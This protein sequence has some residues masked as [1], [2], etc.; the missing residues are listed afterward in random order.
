MQLPELSTYKHQFGLC[1]QPL[2]AT[3]TKACFDRSAC[4]VLSIIAVNQP[5]A[6]ACGASLSH[7][8]AICRYAVS[9][10]R[11]STLRVW[12]AALL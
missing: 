9:E 6:P 2:Q 7:V 1:R 12:P 8:V 11:S 4:N 3:E 10:S 5:K